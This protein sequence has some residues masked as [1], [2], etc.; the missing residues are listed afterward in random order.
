MILLL[1]Y[2]LVFALIIW[3]APWFKTGP[4]SSMMMAMRVVSETKQSASSLTE[5]QT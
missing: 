4:V 3:R 5:D 2:T 1:V